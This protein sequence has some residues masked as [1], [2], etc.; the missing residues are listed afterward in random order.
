MGTAI[1]PF[2][3]VEQMAGKL[4]APMRYA[5]L[6]TL[7]T[8][9]ATASA[10]GHTNT[11]AALVA[12]GLLSAGNAGNHLTTYG[13]RVVAVLD[14]GVV[15]SM[16]ELHAEALDIEAEAARLQMQRWLTMRGV[17][18]TPTPGTVARGVEL[19][20]E[21]ALDYEAR[22]LAAMIP[23][24]GR[25]A[26]VT[27]ALNLAELA[28]DA[29][30]NLRLVK[31]AWSLHLTHLHAE[32]LAEDAER[33]SAHD[34]LCTE[35]C[36]VSPVPAAT[37]YGTGPVAEQVAATRPLSALVAAAAERTG[38]DAAAV[39]TTALRAADGG[40]DNVRWDPDR[41]L[42]QRGWRHATDV[43]VRRV[44]ARVAAF[45]GDPDVRGILRRLADTEV[46]LARVNAELIRRVVDANGHGPACARLHGQP[47]THRPKFGAEQ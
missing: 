7:T 42:R 29:A 13:R 18:M 24:D 34:P 3:T 36:C 44:L 15:A 31:A 6:S 10:L 26:D 1:D 28:T 25:T 39:L 35:R 4:T 5:L 30:E 12:R 17:G 19:D 21:D 47:H 20:H 9:Y 38:R 46:E 16:D 41:V 22:Q 14:P 45:R 40:S 23:I 33:L 27:A 11:L 2:L 32:A 37:R 8:R 43:E